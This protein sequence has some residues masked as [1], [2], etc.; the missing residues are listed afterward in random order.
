M[1]SRSNRA[2]ARPCLDVITL[3]Y[4]C[5]GVRVVQTRHDAPHTTHCRITH[6]MG[7]RGRTTD[8]LGLLE[9]RGVVRTRVGSAR[10]RRA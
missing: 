7:R 3:V 10:Q 4:G 9:T 8:H 6:V 2:C 1:H 5:G